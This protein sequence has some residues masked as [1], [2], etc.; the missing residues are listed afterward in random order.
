M[1]AGD[2]RL[3]QREMAHLDDLFPAGA[4]AGAKY[5]ASGMATLDTDT[6]KARGWSFLRPP[7]DGRAMRPTV[8]PWL[9]AFILAIRLPQIIPLA[10]RHCLR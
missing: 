10:R 1:A 3:T 8:Q 7:G 5:S 2:V 9:A 4:A 6:P